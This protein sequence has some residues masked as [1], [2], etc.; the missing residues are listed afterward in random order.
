MSESLLSDALPIVVVIGALSGELKCSS[1][2][3]RAIWA[4]HD[5]APAPQDGS[6][7]D[8][9]YELSSGALETAL[10]SRRELLST[11]L[12]PQNAGFL[13]SSL[14]EQR[15]R[16]C[17]KLDAWALTLLPTPGALHHS[18]E[19]I[20]HDL[21]Q[22]PFARAE[23]A[24]VG[25]DQGDEIA[26]TAATVPLR[27]DPAPL[28]QAQQQTPLDSPT[29]GNVQP[30]SVETQSLPA[31]SH[32][33][34]FQAAQ[35][36][37]HPQQPE[38]VLQERQPAQGQQQQR[39]HTALPTASSQLRGL[40]SHADM[41]HDG[42]DSGYDSSSRALFSSSATPLELPD[43][44]TLTPEEV[45]ALAA[46][47]SSHQ[48]ILMSHAL[49]EVN[50]PSERPWGRGHS[51]LAQEGSSGL[52][53]PV[54]RRI[55]DSATSMYQPRNG[56]F[57]SQRYR[58]PD[59]EGAGMRSS[60][61]EWAQGAGGSPSS[62]VGA[63]AAVAD[64]LILQHPE[65][66]GARASGRG[67]EGRR[68][69]APHVLAAPALYGAATARAAS[70]SAVV[71]PAD[72]QG[73]AMEAPNAGGTG[74][75]GVPLLTAG[76]LDA[77]GHRSPVS[78][79]GVPP[80]SITEGEAE[81]CLTSSGENSPTLQTLSEWA[82]APNEEQQEP[83]LPWRQQVASPAVMAA[84]EAATTVASL[85]A[86]I[87]GAAT[88]AEASADLYGKFTNSAAAAELV[89]AEASPFTFA[90]A[91]AAQQS[92]QQ[93]Q[94][95]QSGQS[96][97]QPNNIQ[98]QAGV[99]RPD[100]AV[101]EHRFVR[102][103]DTR[104]RV[105]TLLRVYDTAQPTA[106]AA[107][108]PARYAA[109]TGH[110]APWEATA[111]AAAGP[112][113]APRSDLG[114]TGLQ[115]RAL[116]P[117]NFPLTNGED[118]GC[119]SRPIASSG[120]EGVATHGTV[121]GG[122]EEGGDATEPGTSA[123]AAGARWHQVRL[124]LIMPPCIEEGPEGAAAPAADATA[125]AADATAAA[126]PV[127]LRRWQHE[128]Y[129]QLV[130]YDVD[131]LVRAAVAAETQVAELYERQVRL[132]T[133]LA[134]EH[135]LLEAIFP[136]QAIEHMTRVIAAQSGL[137]APPATP[138]HPKSA[139]TDADPTN[140]TTAAAADAAAEAAA[141]AARFPVSAAMNRGVIRVPSRPSHG[142]LGSLTLPRGLAPA[143][144]AAATCT[145]G[146]PATQEVTAHTGSAT[147]A[148]E[149]LDMP[150]TTTAAAAAATSMAGVFLG[151]G[152]GSSCA[153]VSLGSS[154]GK[155]GGGGAGPSA[156]PPPQV[157]AAAPMAAFAP[158]PV[159]SAMLPLATCH[160]HV[161]VLFADIVGFTSMCNCLEPMEVMTFL[162]GLFTRFD[163]LCDVYGV[164]KVETIGD[165]FMAV[166]GL[167]TLDCEGFRAVRGDGAEDGLHALKVMSFAKALL[168]EAARHVMPH[169]G[170]PLRMRVGLHSG[171]VTSGIVGS[172]MPRFCLFGDTVNTAS[173]MESTCE[174]GAVH[175]SG[176][177][178]EL[179]P[180]EQW[181]PTGGVVVKGK[182]E[183]QTFLWR[184]PHDCS[185]VKA[186]LS[187]P[188]ALMAPGL[189]GGRSTGPLGGLLTAQDG[190]R[191]AGASA[192]SR[193]A[194][195]D[196]EAV[197]AQ[198]ARMRLAAAGAV[199]GSS[200]SGGGGDGAG[201]Q[202]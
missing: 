127:R 42:Y 56:P 148:S 172:K 195:S 168:R 177:T 63:A 138:R 69:G 156:P 57:A 132:E 55:L 152:V 108:A 23:E 50:D 111:A 41:R 100:V 54:V 99:S 130:S 174:P 114:P 98:N 179:L 155:G 94:L 123:G 77:S 48:H 8:T 181:T 200:G 87:A 202:V 35:R 175:A 149:D 194:V 68:L 71:A 117:G 70:S 30:S 184:P 39:P 121:G 197:R 189:L 3:A 44:L 110:P 49:M 115:G 198:I 102:R 144:P 62:A 65:I 163:S 32:P 151:G 119:S 131:E 180:G 154:P 141:A 59:G 38:E 188:L 29:H 140:N 51:A 139:P 2:A 153:L 91:A 11:L 137:S 161:T 101:N 92:G 169:D 76:R 201:A 146:A 90:L 120:F 166:G 84:L 66:L 186:F 124:R 28:Q 159:S 95:S 80:P 93:Q 72:P 26:V 19:A 182:G 185:E 143:E 118:T 47:D 15:K 13:L 34:D 24:G 4:I 160:R 96:A 7:E 33:H 113:L 9:L 150:T 25:G 31:G 88:A 109:G 74:T 14:L 81:G 105:Q 64:A 165:C 190:G 6:I 125:V 147:L 164:Y 171:P 86:A 22:R 126:A 82:Q 103:S 5:L 199:A 78:S 193:A 136:R 83:S 46:G 128:P 170:Q 43:R 79:V 97:A 104:S 173:R 89:D 158:A 67:S 122:V 36:Q 192:A 167:I 40:S 196:G 135:K 85:H 58:M 176:A 178:R 12:G 18:P 116:A 20:P 112:T 106:A 10:S 187:S 145:R 142:Q 73:P 191:G 45:E 53:D 21:G 52:L 134:H 16:E 17:A 61:L 75:S 37:Q 129:L 157:A 162:N 27:V 60:A 1:P 183:M 133:L 107:A